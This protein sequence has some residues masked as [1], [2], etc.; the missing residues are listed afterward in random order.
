MR[1]ISVG[2][3]GCGVVGSAVVQSLHKDADTIAARCGAVFEVKKIAV[4]DTGKNRSL[5]VDPQGVITSNVD[6]VL[7]APDIDMVVELMGGDEAAYDAITKAIDNGKHVVTANKLVL[8]KRGEEIFTAAGKAGVEL[9]F[10]ASVAGGVPVIRTIKEA[11][12]SGGIKSVFGIING[13]A[14]YILTEMTKKNESFQDALAAAKKLGYAEAD[15]TFDVDGIDAAHKITILANLAFGTPVD[16]ESVYVE[17]I[18][19]ISPDD[20]YFAKQFGQVIK[21]LA[22][23]RIES[24]KVDVRVHPSMVPELSPMAH[25]NGVTNAV[26]LE[27]GGVGKLML[28][29]AG[30]GGEPTASSVIADM[31]EIARNIES[32]SVGRVSPFAFMKEARR[33]L[34]MKPIEEITSGYYLRFSV[35]DKPGVLAAMSSILGKHGIGIA[36]VIQKGRSHGPVPLVILTHDT[37]EKELRLAVKELDQLESTKEKT[38]IIRLENGEDNDENGQ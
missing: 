36:S 18:K 1:K 24:G 10:E 8:A 37:R 31:V 34:P 3:L 14:N 12:A 35:F 16:F 22:T 6:D 2:L 27:I 26:E 5:P 30:A 13:T 28:I 7:L 23:A 21:L 38:V 20:I 25:I 17:G 19:E 4:R 11:V 9:G 33:K 32:G 29:G 15:P